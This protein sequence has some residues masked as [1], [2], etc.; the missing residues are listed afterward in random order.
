MPTGANEGSPV[1]G[2]MADSITFVL[3]PDA[4]FASLGGLARSIEAIRRLIRHV[5]YAATR[6]K[7][8]RSW[9]VLRIQS[10]APTLTL[11]PP[12]GED[13]AIQIIADGL[14][15]VAETGTNIPPAF[16]SEDALMDLSHMS[17]LFKGR[18][19]IQRVAVSI[20]TEAD[21]TPLSAPIATIRQD[22]PQKVAP[23]MRGG[24]SE[25]GF[26]EGTLE[27]VNL[28]APPS[29][30]IWERVSG[31]PVRCSF[32]K[33]QDWKMRIRELLETPVLV[34]GQVSYFGNGV[35]RSMTQIEDVRGI[36]PDPA[37]PKADFGTIPDLTG[38]LGTI[39]YL[40][41][42]RGG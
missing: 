6:R 28:H 20:T 8:G 29:F 24:Y 26:L 35:P 1:K 10:T 32:P 41:A 17:R 31:L 30:T 11:K 5:D 18:D 4:E 19:R 33:R 16:F 42:I 12:P 36:T 14:K 15:L 38:E 40:R 27:A 22:I 37:L 7:A 3:Q 2:I 39:E 25:S 9:Q 21:S 23:I 13:D 34:T